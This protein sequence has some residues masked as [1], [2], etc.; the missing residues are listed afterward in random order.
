M[1]NYALHLKSAKQPMEQ[2]KAFELATTTVH[3]LVGGYIYI[4]SYKALDKLICIERGEYINSN[5]S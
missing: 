5:K 1:F 2:I 3:L 4:T